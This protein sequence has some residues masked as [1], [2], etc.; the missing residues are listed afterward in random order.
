MV[1][2]LRGQMSDTLLQQRGRQHPSHQAWVDTDRVSNYQKYIKRLTR[3]VRARRGRENSVR[4]EYLAFWTKFVVTYSLPRSLKSLTYFVLSD[5]DGRS[6][7]VGCDGG[8]ACA[9]NARR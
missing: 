7:L 5:H 4:I 2:K 6:D 3:L 8:A 1:R 9:S